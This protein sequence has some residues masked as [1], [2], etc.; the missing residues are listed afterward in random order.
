MLHG[1]LIH[2]PLTTADDSIDTGFNMLTVLA[3]TNAAFA[4]LD[5]DVRSKLIRKGFIYIQTCAPSNTSCLGALTFFVLLFSHCADNLPI[6]RKLIRFH[7][8]EDILS[9]SEVCA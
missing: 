2:I 8:V 9:E 7:F 6:L 1:T 4:K 5:K 3:P